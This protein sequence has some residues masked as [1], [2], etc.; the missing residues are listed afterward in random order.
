MTRSRWISVLAIAAVFVPFA[1]VS[2]QD[3]KPELTEVW[4]PEPLLVVPGEGTAP[5]SDAI[6]L[7]DGTSLDAWQTESDE[8]PARWIVGDGAMTVSRGGGNIRTREAFGD[9]QLHIE[10][11]TPSV[12]EG[13]GQGRGNSGVF[14]QGRYEVQV[15]D[16]YENRTYSN[17][18]AASIYKQHAPL[19]NASR[20]PGQWQA[21]DIY[22]RAPVFASDGDL[23]RK[24]TVTVVHNGVLVQ[25]DSEIQGDTE[26]IGLPSYT[27]HGDGPIVLQD[28]GNPTS[29]RNVWVRKLED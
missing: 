7:F 13:D 16:S 15:L 23:V 10:W 20:P 12:V 18:Q 1:S 8:S 14:L 25:L 11:R 5:P 17:G 22:Y 9:V 24:A 2:A 28:H 26:Y 6:V 4:E 27:P 29:Y 3:W 19:V 21:Y